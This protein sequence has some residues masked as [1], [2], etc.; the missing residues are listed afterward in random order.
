MTFFRLS[1]LAYKACISELVY[2][3]VCSCYSRMVF[4]FS[5]QN[6]EDVRLV[7]EEIRPLIIKID[8]NLQ[9]KYKPEVYR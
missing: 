6:D 2:K 4:F 5:F 9:L 7:L 1:D 3:M 8:G